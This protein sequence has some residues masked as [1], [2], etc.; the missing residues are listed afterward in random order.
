MQLWGKHNPLILQVICLLGMSSTLANRKENLPVNID[1]CT[2]VK[3]NRR[4]LVL[5]VNSTCFGSY[6]SETKHVA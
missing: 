1:V 5:S 2:T 4:L 6:V 3:H